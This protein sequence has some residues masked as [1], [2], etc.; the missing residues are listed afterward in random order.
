M[1]KFCA[2]GSDRFLKTLA[3]VVFLATLT[4]PFT[5][6]A[7]GQGAAKA[8]FEA[9]E[10]RCETPAGET[11]EQC[12]LT[13]TVK[14]EDAANVN[15]GVMIVRPK[16]A[17]NGLFRVIAPM[18]VFLLNGVSLKIDQ[19][20]IGR[21]AFFR[22]FPSGCLADVVIDDKLVEQLKNG[23]IATLVIYLTPYEGIRHLLMLKGFKEGYDKLP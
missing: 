9:W 20:D 14:A 2:S 5:G 17:K 19:T 1:M 8:K 11:S 16:D 15:L 18:S 23:K 10:L 4:S 6:A 7:F 21:A 3:S 12:A 22:C 13:Q